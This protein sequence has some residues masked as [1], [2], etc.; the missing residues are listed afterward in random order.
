MSISKRRA[1]SKMRAICPWIAVGIGAAADQV[2]TG[3]AGRDQ[4]LLRARVI[5]AS[6]GNTQMSRSIAQA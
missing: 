4:Q 1:I 3:L 2:G 5:A 6:C